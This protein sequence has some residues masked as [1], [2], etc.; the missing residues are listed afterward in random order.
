VLPNHGH[1]L[2]NPMVPFHLTPRSEAGRDIRIEHS[3]RSRLLNLDVRQ[4]FKEP[5]RPVHE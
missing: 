5:V 2:E 4:V 3:L 1:K